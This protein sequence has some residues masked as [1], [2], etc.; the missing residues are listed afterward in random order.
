MALVIT[1]TQARR[2]VIAGDIV[3][4]FDHQS[5]PVKSNDGA[6]VC[7]EFDLS[8]NVAAGVAILA[9]ILGLDEVYSCTMFSKEI[10][11]HIYSAPTAGDRKS[12]TLTTKTALDGVDLANDADAGV[13]GFIAWGKRLGTVR[14]LPV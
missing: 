1:H 13:L 14:T 4:A 10:E 7:G 11:G 5:P 8:S 12:V 3:E 2:I 6:L 9:G